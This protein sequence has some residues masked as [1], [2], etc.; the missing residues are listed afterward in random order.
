MVSGGGFK[1]KVVEAIV[2]R[3]YVV[4]TPMAVEF[5]DPDT[6]RLIAVAGSPQE[7]AE[8]IVQLLRNP[9]TCTSRLSALYDRIAREFTWSKRAVE[10]LAITRAT[11]QR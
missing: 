10:L 8:M 1:N 3:T 6:R 2:N 9:A 4:A 7:M 5:L 11:T